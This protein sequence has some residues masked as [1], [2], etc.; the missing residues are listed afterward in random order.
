MGK[1]GLLRAMQSKSGRGHFTES[2]SGNTIVWQNATYRYNKSVI[3]H[4]NLFNYFNLYSNREVKLESLIL[5]KSGKK[6]KQKQKMSRAKYNNADIC[7]PSDSGIWT[8]RFPK[9]RNQ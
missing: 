2:S 7:F 9:S 4:K 3:P 8:N 1:R 6:T 5:R